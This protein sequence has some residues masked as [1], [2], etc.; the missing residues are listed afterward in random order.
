MTYELPIYI[1]IV[2]CAPEQG[3]L[4]L[5]LIFKNLRYVPLYFTKNGNGQNFCLDGKLFSR[6]ICPI[7]FFTTHPSLEIVLSLYNLL[8]DMYIL[9]GFAPSLL[10]Q[11]GTEV[12]DQ[13]KSEYSIQK[14]HH[15]YSLINLLLLKT[16]VLFYSF[17]RLSKTENKPSKHVSC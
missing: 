1:W 14:I 3:G 13:Q 9:Q 6:N 10:K 4:F 2:D 7:I 12:F 15:L 11:P 16:K 17:K 5:G 8:I